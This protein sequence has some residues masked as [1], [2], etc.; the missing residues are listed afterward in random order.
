MAGQLASLDQ[1]LHYLRSEGYYAAEDALVREIEDRVPLASAAS[2]S[3]SGSGS[4]ESHRAANLPGKLF[5]ASPGAEES[6]VR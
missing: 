1:I 5:A 3:S 2:R 6:P 4:P